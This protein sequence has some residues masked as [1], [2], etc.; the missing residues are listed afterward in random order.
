MGPSASHICDF[1]GTWS[2]PIKCATKCGP[3]GFC[4][5]CERGTQACVDAKR[6]HYCNDSGVWEEPQTCDFAC[7]E[8]G[9]R[10]CKPG[11]TQCPTGDAVQTCT[12]DGEWGD[13]TACANVC[14]NGACT[15][16]PKKV[17]VTSTTYKGGDLGGLTGADAKC[18][19]RAVAG[20][21]KG[22]FKAWL[23][24]FTGSPSTRFT[25]DG[26]PYSLVN[27]SIV[28]SNWSALVSGFLR[29]A[30]NINELG[31]AAPTTP[32]LVCDYPLVWTNTT[33]DGN[34]GDFAATCG[35]WT[36]S[37]SFTSWWG[38][39]ASQSSWSSACSGGNSPMTGCSVLAPIFCFEQ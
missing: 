1:D 39:T 37:S 8:G 32:S 33:S 30:I 24:D 10:S 21:L 27:G 38:T 2:E 29:H 3:D 28:A 4:A 19:A 25:Q 9:C 35:D 26:G 14:R 6:V 31:G 5:D 13:W 11:Q 22:T 17:F 18:Q 36:D 34:V 16:N 23:S 12:S 7:S 20:G 15:T